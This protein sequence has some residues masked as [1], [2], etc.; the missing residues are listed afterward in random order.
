M[1]DLTLRALRVLRGSCFAGTRR[2][3]S[4][5]GAAMTVARQ[6]AL[7]GAVLVLLAG[8]PSAAAASRVIFTVDV[9]SNEQ[10]PLPDQID[11]VCADGSACGLMEMVRMLNTHRWPGTFFLDV[12]EHRQWGE[13][14]MRRIAVELQDA[15]QDVALHTHPQWAYDPSRRAMHEYSLEEQITIV[16]DGAKLLQEWT[17]RPVVAHRAGAYTANE[18]TLIA[19]ERNGVLLD[20]SVFWQHPE[21]RLDT[22]GLSRNVPSRHGELTEIPVTVYERHDRPRFLGAVLP[23][24]TVVRKI[25]PNWFINAAEARDAIDAVLAAD[26]PVLVVFLHSYSF[27]AGQSAAGRPLI[28]Q[29]AVEMFRAIV[30]EL[31]ARKLPVVTMRE[32]AEQKPSLAS[33]SRDVVPGVSTTADLSRY[34][35]RGMKGRRLLLLAALSVALAIAGTVVVT[36]RRGGHTR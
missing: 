32:L 22:A 29:H 25:D 13:D 34:I 31:A 9:E 23:P 3:A 20:S 18:N 33:I 8:A 5:R 1:F 27:M 19:L 6:L 2:A 10:F 21:S 24:V 12:Y 16:R 17:G 4:R 15:G 14:A 7:A 28:D 26:I 11:A 30:D 36:V 35:W